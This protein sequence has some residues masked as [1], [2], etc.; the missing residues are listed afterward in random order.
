MFILFLKLYFLW[1]NLIMN[2]RAKR[3]GMNV[4]SSIIVIFIM[5]VS[6][7]ALINIVFN[8]VY[9]KTPVRG[10]S[11]QPTFNASV[12]DPNIDGDTAYVN[13]YS[14]YNV[15]DI[16]VASVS[17]WDKGTII[18]RLIAKPGDN[19][20]IVENDNSYSLIVNGTLLYSI[21]KNGNT[22]HDLE[23]ENY[24]NYYTSYVDAR[25]GTAS[26]QLDSEGQEV[27][28]MQENEYF[29]MGDNWLESEDCLLHGPVTA[30]EIIGRVE[31]VIKYG[32]NRVFSLMQQMLSIAFSV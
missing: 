3:I 14:S 30:N 5:V 27:V 17:W 12:S 19:F 15:N 13:R 21:E 24:Y 16:V 9:I 6:F 18:K 8:F 23:L 32:E 26:I 7:F 1:Y 11:M 31:M 25:R 20:K 10:F 29:L 28:V 4:L 2:A 22:I